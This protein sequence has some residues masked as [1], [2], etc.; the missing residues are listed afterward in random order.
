MSITCSPLVPEMTG[1][2]YCLSCKVS[3]AEPACFAASSLG[4]VFGSKLMLSSC[5]NAWVTVGTKG[6]RAPANFLVQPCLQNNTNPT[7]LFAIN[8][9]KD[10]PQLIRC[11]SL[12]GAAIVNN[13]VV[14]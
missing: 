4:V 5:R 8:D 12:I 10:G 9:G 6:D 2:S 11:L 14:S 1:N 7:A 3:V 13:K